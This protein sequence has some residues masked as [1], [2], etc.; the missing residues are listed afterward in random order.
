MAEVDGTE[1]DEMA[2]VL[3]DLQRRGTLSDRRLRLFAC[4]CCRFM[5][6][7][8]NREGLAVVELAERLADGRVTPD[9]ARRAATLVRCL[10]WD[11]RALEAVT[12]LPRWFGCKA[13]TWRTVPRS[14]LLR[15]LL[16]T[17]AAASLDPVWLAWNDGTVARLAAGIYEERAFDRLPILADALEDAGCTDIVLLEHCR[18]PGPHAR[19]CWALDFIRGAD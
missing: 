13:L 15:D 1:A 9:E 14:A 8:G 4:A 3:R 16:G 11:Q 2:S 18:G 12:E 19:G 10:S 6:R 5:D 17:P 7:R